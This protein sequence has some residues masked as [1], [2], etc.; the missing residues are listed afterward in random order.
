VFLVLLALALGVNAAIPSIPA[1]T[2][3][4]VTAALI[5]VWVAIRDWPHR[6]YYLTVTA[7]VG[8][9]FA[10]TSSGVGV[11]PADFTLGTLFVL[12]GISF[13]PVGVLDH[14]LLVRLMRE[15]RLAQTS[16]S[17]SAGGL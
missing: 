7:A 10:V 16:S 13:V 9:G 11:L 5:S 15:A 14:L 12:L 1:G 3:T 17:T 4:A 6:R 8:L 2:P